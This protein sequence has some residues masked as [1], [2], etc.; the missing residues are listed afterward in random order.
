MRAAAGTARARRWKALVGTKFSRVRKAIATGEFGHVLLLHIL[1]RDP[2]SSPARHVA[3]CG[4]AFLDRAI[5]DVA[6]TSFLRGR[7]VEEIYTS[8]WL[9]A[10]SWARAEGVAAGA[11]IVFAL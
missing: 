10:D 4:G 11:R 9:Q 6:M 1:R 8:A 7:E 3:Q 2:A 5:P